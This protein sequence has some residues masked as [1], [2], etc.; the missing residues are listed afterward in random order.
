MKHKHHIS[1]SLNRFNL[2]IH[3]Y[4]IQ[5]SLSNFQLTKVPTHR[6]QPLLH[7]TI[8]KVFHSTMLWGGAFYGFPSFYSDPV[9]QHRPPNSGPSYNRRRNK[10][11]H[12]AEP[13]N[14]FQLVLESTGTVFCY[15][16]TGANRCH[17]PIDAR[18]NPGIGKVW[19]TPPKNPFSIADCNIT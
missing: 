10:G 19:R 12:K 13:Q 18:N 17:G 2:S 14:H 8:H 1:K 5:S 9:F 15:C 4:K 11:S 7:Y 6:Q 16:S 3:F